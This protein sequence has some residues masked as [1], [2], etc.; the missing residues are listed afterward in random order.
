DRAGAGDAGPHQD[1]SGD[2]LVARDFELLRSQGLELV[3]T[4]GSGDQGRDEQDWFHAELMEQG[5]GPTASVQKSR[6]CG[7]QAANLVTHGLTRFAGWVG[8]RGGVQTA[9]DV[10]ASLRR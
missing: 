8:P 5:P 10:Q 2:L 9:A 6:T 1:F 3:G 4:G 7:S